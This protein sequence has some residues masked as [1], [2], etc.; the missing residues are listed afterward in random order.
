VLD[1]F[2]PVVAKHPEYADAAIIARLRAPERQII[3]RVPWTDDAGQVQMNRGFRV[4][5]NSARHRTGTKVP[6]LGCST[7]APTASSRRT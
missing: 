3:F 7:T 1:S 5:F 4:G 6:D 2:G